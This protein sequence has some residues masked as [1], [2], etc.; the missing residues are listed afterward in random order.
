[1]EFHGIQGLNPDGFENSGP[2]VRLY[3]NE[4]VHTRE[5][6]RIH[7]IHGIHGNSM[8]STRIGTDCQSP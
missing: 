6:M 5:V 4:F 2:E 1:M 3:G 8:K 7:G